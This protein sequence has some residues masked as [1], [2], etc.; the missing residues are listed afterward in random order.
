M[1]RKAT[2]AKAAN[3]PVGETVEQVLGDLSHSP[4]NAPAEVKY[5]SM[6]DDL[7]LEAENWL[8]GEPLSSQD[9]ADQ[10]TRL[11]DAAAKLEKQIEADRKAEKEPH[12]EAGRA[13]DA[14]FKP[15]AERASQI[16]RLAKKALTP[17]LEAVQAEKRRKELE[18][19]KAAEDARARLAEQHRATV[20]NATFADE[21]VTEQMEADAKDAEKAAREAAKQ[22]VT[23]KGGDTTIKLRPVWLVNMTNPA[24]YLKH[25]KVA[26]PDE[27]KAFLYD[28]ARK[29]VRA[30]SRSLP[31]CSIWSEQKAA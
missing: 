15:L 5:D 4:E 16:V 31:G 3:P 11:V 2:S 23:T 10:V 19:I 9:Q 26:H 28:Q 17:W 25:C 14:K 18:A 12:L 22:S 7:K 20:D 21:R 30:G 1:A 24:E 29:D 27:L 6:L 13:V 8:D